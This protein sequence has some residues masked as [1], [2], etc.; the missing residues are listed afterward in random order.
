MMKNGTA[1][2]SRH[3]AFQQVNYVNTFACMPRFKV[4][5]S[6]QMVKTHGKLTIKEIYDL[7]NMYRSS[8]ES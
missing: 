1:L 5:K 4:Y 7:D 2:A 6:I 3:I 8:N